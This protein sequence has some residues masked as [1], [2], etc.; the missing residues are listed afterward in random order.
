MTRSSVAF[1][2]PVMPAEGGNGLAMRAGLFLEGLAQAGSVRVLVIPVFGSPGESGWAEAR[3]ASIGVLPL[4]PGAARVSDAVARLATPWGRATAAAVGTRPIWCQAATMAA[5]E[6]ATA[7]VR[8]ADLVHVFRLYLAPY[9][10]RLLDPGVAGRPRIMLDVDDRD[11]STQRL[12]GRPGQ[13]E[14]FARLEA[15]YLPRV[16]QVITAAPAD[17]CDLQADH[18][19][20]AVTAVPNAVRLPVAVDAAGPAFDL[21]FVG[22]LSYGPNIEAARWLAE[23]VVPLLGSVRVAIVGS[24]PDP[25]VWALA[26]RDPRITVAGD[27]DSVGPWYAGA[28]MVVVPV[29][30]GGGTH[31]KVIE[32]F[33]HRRPVVTTRLGAAGLPFAGAGGCDSDC[34]HRSGPLVIADDPVSFAAACR[35]MLDS[36]S[37]AAQLAQEGAAEVVRTSTV[38]VVAPRIAGLARHILSS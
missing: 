28:T 38:A 26:D 9:L 16:D 1:L 11:Q 18:H 34:A 6:A 7:F 25:A 17:A 21:L 30:R 13:A 23:E 4:V 32:A 12:A 27:V 22:N 33:A 24:S 15:H 20:R 2:T 3:A 35:A 37:L 10:D 19:L 29:F 8:G 36:P 5:T 31:T 14:A